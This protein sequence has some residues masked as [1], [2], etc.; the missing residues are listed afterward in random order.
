[1]WS[2][3][4]PKVRKET[5]GQLKAATAFSQSG[6]SSATHI[7]SMTHLYLKYCFFCVWIYLYVDLCT[8]APELQNRRRGG[9]YPAVYVQS[10]HGQPLQIWEM[11]SSE[12]HL[13]V[14]PVIING[15]R[16]NKI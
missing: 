12:V 2:G 15:N 3:H 4:P 13:T 14:L 5:A 8:T 7:F 1:M 10:R 11:K 6:A 9:P 16:G